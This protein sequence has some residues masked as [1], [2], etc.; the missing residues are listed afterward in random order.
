MCFALWYFYFCDWQ[1]KMFNNLLGAS[2]TC[3]DNFIARFVQFNTI[4]IPL[5]FITNKI[6]QITSPLTHCARFLQVGSKCLILATILTTI[7]NQS[8]LNI[9]FYCSTSSKVSTHIRV[10]SYLN[11]FLA[12]FEISG[13]GKI[14][15]NQMMCIL[16]TWSIPPLPTPLR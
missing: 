11:I 10:L 9:F 15:K 1:K 5:K 3:R 12:I 4:F 14:F 16:S 7:T 6:K 13:R 2:T 8:K